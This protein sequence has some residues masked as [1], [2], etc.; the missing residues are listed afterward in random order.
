MRTSMSI[1]SLDLTHFRCHIKKEIALSP[2]LTVISGANAHGKTSMLEALYMLSRG[3][4]FREMEEKELLTF[5]KEYGAVVGELVDA[6]GARTESAIT[7]QQSQHLLRKRYSLDKAPV[8]LVAYRRAQMPVVLFA[9][10]HI[11]IITHGPANRREFLNDTL[12]AT[13]QSYAKTLREYDSALRKRNI[14]LESYESLIALQR[15]IRFW[16]EYL[17]SRADMLT[18]ARA[19]LVQFFNVHSTFADAHVHMSY[20]PN[21]M[22][23]ERLVEKFATEAAARRTLIGP[24]KDDFVLSIQHGEEQVNAHLYAS[25]SQQRLCLLW[26]KMRELVWTCE[27]SKRAPLLLLDDV[28]SEFDS[29]HKQLISNLIPAYQTVITTTEELTLPAHIHQEATIVRV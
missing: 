15:D 5:G 29:T 6:E 14:L 26:L 8:G 24:Q 7:Y 4:G 17:V 10:H 12:S 19:Q 1:T 25:R 18:K 23:H 28:Y 16:D 22:T 20:V 3:R 11:D 27:V 13:H 21:V 9:P 2:V